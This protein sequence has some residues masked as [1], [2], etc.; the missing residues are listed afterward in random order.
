VRGDHDEYGELI[1]SVED[2]RKQILKELLDMRRID[3]TPVMGRVIAIYIRTLQAAEA[4]DKDGRLPSTKEIGERLESEAA[5]H[6]RV[7]DALRTVAARYQ[8]EVV[9]EWRKS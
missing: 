2:T 3:A 6:R 1:L 7:H 4:P 8:Y 5:I 9:K